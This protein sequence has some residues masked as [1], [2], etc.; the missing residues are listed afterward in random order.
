MTK[1]IGLTGP[2]GSGKDEVASHFKRRRAYVVDVD[3]LAHTLYEPQS[4]IWRAI[5]QHFGTDVL[6]KGGI[7]SRRRL[8]QLV[9]SDPAKLRELNHIIHP[10]LLNRVAKELAAARAAGEKIVVVNAALLRKIGLDKL[11]DEIWVVA[12]KEEIRLKRLIK[13]GQSQKEV[14]ACMKAQGKIK[15]FLAGADVIIENN[16]TLAALKKKFDQAFS[17]LLKT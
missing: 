9:F 17:A 10:P 13:R 15:E 1:I 3:E 2:I 5:V 14:R 8:A 4:V 16:S 11:V 7:I 6:M 12:A